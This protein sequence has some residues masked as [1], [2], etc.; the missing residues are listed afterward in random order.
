MTPKK[1]L[2]FVFTLVLLTALE[3]PAQ[4]SWIWSPDIGKWINPK[5]AAKDTPE[6]QYGWAMGFYNS[7][8]WD[9]AIEEFDKIPEYFPTSRLAAEG[10]YY[11]G[12][13]WEEKKDIAKAADSFKKLVDKYPY[14]DRIKDAI[15]HEFDIANEFARGQKLKVLGIAALPAQDKA[16]ELYQHVVKNAPF[17]TYGD[18]AQ[19]KIG[20]L[21][22]TQGE[23]EDAQKA[24]QALVDEYPGSPLSAQASFEIATAS[25]L[26]SEKSQYDEQH[27]ERAIQEFQ[28]YK[29]AFPTDAKSL[30]AE[31][32]IREL[33]T[34]KAQTSYNIA[35]FYEKQGKWDSAKVYYQ[36]V[37][38]K[39]SDT[40][41]AET[42]KKKAQQMLEKQSQPPAGKKFGIF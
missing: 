25:R 39:Y 13:S 3:L 26:A 41:L 22:K 23:Y 37:A 7:K 6:D 19:F 28:G 33:R 15:K 2:L 32:S 36:E 40:S 21:Y 34:K 38:N 35:A 18:Q 8:Q 1:S 20:E 12:L 14:S 31:Q 42:A 9:R 5:K 29:N 27:A 4:A 24:F 16:L 17:G 10:V 30:E 11:A